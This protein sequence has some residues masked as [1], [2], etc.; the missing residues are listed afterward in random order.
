MAKVSNK[1]PL[2]KLRR[3]R[4]SR[5]AFFFIIELLL[6]GA[7]SQKDEL[8]EICRQHV[9]GK[10]VVLLGE[11]NYEKTPALIKN[12]IAT[13]VPSVPVGGV[14]EATSLAALESLALGVPVIASNIGGLTEIDNGT[15]IMNLVRPGE[16]HD[17]SEAMENIYQTFLENKIDRQRLKS[18]ILDNFDTSV[19]CQKIVNVY[20][21]TLQERRTRLI[22]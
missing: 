6:A 5:S 19:W 10:K 11:V 7:G 4:S 21:K 13:I 14:T 18:H 3:A 16:S 15:K 8:V 9:N 12:A 17:I 1:T 22:K 20:E 2:L